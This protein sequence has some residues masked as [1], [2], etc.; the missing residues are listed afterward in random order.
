[1]DNRCEVYIVFVGLVLY[2]ILTV[3]DPFRG[4]IVVDPTTFEHLIQTLRAEIG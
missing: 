4:G 2:L 1:M 3:G